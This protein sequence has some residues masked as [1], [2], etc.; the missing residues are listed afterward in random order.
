MSHL[1]IPLGLYPIEIPC[2][3]GNQSYTSF[4]S[5]YTCTPGCRSPG[6][7]LSPSVAW[8]KVKAG[9]ETAWP[10]FQGQQL[11]CFSVQALGLWCNVRLIASTGAETY[12]PE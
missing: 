9:R 7:W 6:P 4:I 8:M 2:T 3:L 12:G 5:N 1:T 10:A 11:G